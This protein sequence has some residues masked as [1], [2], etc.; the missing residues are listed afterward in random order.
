[1]PFFIKSSVLGPLLMG[2]FKPIDFWGDQ[3]SLRN[4]LIESHCKGPKIPFLIVSTNNWKNLVHLKS[5]NWFW[6]WVFLFEKVWSHNGVLSLLWI[7]CPFKMRTP[8][9]LRK[10]VVCSFSSYK[11]I[12]DSDRHK[13]YIDEEGGGGIIVGIK[14]WPQRI[15][16]AR[17][18]RYLFDAIS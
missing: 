13:P 1:M 7:A 8:K 6:I 9:I 3:K 18:R 14:K 17:E 4:S 2:S 10:S 12:H 5:K 15:R 16:E 11:E